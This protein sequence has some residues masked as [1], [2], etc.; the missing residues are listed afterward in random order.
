MGEKIFASGSKWIRIDLH[1][2]TKAD[3]KF[4]YNGDD[5]IKDYI[6]A[7]KKAEIKIAGI[8]NHNKFDFDK[9]KELK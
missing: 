1:L 8:T 5:F 4:K 9:F 3:N 6:N 7:L 2:H